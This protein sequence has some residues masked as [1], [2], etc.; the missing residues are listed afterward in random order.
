MHP[1][2][3]LGLGSG[4]CFLCKGPGLV[5]TIRPHPGLDLRSRLGL[6]VGFGFGQGAGSGAQRTSR[7]CGRPPAYPPTRRLHRC[8]GCAVRSARSC[9][10]ASADGS[11]ASSSPVTV[12]KRGC[13]TLCDLVCSGSLGNRTCQCTQ[14]PIY[15]VPC[16]AAG[17]KGTGRSLSRLHHPPE[18]KAS[19][20]SREVSLI[21]RSQD[22]SFSYL[23]HKQAGLCACT[24]T[25]YVYLAPRVVS[26]AS[27]GREPPPLVITPV[28]AEPP[29]PVGVR[30]RRRRAGQRRRKR[31]TPSIYR[32]PAIVPSVI[33]PDW[34]AIV[35][36]A[37]VR[38]GRSGAYA[39]TLLMP[40][41]C[42]AHLL[43][44]PCTCTCT[45]RAHPLH[46]PCTCT[47][48]CR[49]AVHIPWLG[50]HA[51]GHADN[52]GRAADV[53]HHS[54]EGEHLLHSPCNVSIY[55]RHIH[56]NVCMCMHHA[57]IEACPWCTPGARVGHVPCVYRACTKH[58][59]ACAMHRLYMHHALLYTI[60][61]EMHC[62]MHLAAAGAA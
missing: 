9:R 47:F 36:A 14:K 37:V 16:R 32:F 3:A 38:K 49:H 29:L 21:S 60:L 61:C 28:G 12:Y 55:Y 27:V 53:M 42:R 26:A 5:R 57:Y 48:T 4:R 1:S 44:M 52:E 10:S 7:S 50:R 54:R 45:C 59:N 40:C 11:C 31:R 8:T 62:E 58:H 18:P 46:M 13:V 34:I 33:S 25:C 41:A 6:W 24:C 22:I 43:H 56:M 20:G 17:A 35:P 2:I 39:H 19:V 51:G 30:R 15:S 23:A